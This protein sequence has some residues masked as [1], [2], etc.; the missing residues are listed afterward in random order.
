MPYHTDMMI[1]AVFLIGNS[2]TSQFGL[3]FWDIFSYLYP[4]HLHINF[5][6]H[7]L[8]SLGYQPSWVQS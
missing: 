2:E 8:I 6:I 5:R 1:P 4:F 3:L 7:L